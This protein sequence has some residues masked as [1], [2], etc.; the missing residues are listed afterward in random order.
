MRKQSLFGLEGIRNYCLVHAQACPFLIPT[1]HLWP[2]VSPHAADPPLLWF[3]VILPSLWSTF[4]VVHFR[5]GPTVV[6]LSLWF[7]LRCGSTFAVVPLSL[8]FRLRCGSTFAVAPLSPL[9]HLRCGSAFAVVPPSPWFHLRC[10]ST[11]GSE[12]SR[13]LA[14]R[15]R[16]FGGRGRKRARSGQQRAR[17]GS[18]DSGVGK[19]AWLGGTRRHGLGTCGRD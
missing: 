16:G 6:P 7:R 4:P 15:E 11:L 3:V 14:A 8:W 17:F 12:K 10:G 2:A 19:K 5:C 18:Q 13:D 1:M 9:L